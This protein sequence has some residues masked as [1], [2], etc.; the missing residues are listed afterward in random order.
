MHTYVEAISKCLAVVKK[1]V[2]VGCKEVIAM[3]KHF[4]RC[5]TADGY[6]KCAVLTPSRQAVGR[7][8]K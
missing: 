8:G 4:I 7:G 1:T 6:E 2:P 5:D 3:N